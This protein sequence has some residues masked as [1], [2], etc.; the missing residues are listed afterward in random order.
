MRSAKRRLPAQAI[1]GIELRREKKDSRRRGFAIG[2]TI[3][4]L[5]GA[6]G[7]AMS[8]K[9]PGDSQ[10]LGALLGAAAG[11]AVYGGIGYAIGR[12]SDLAW[13]PVEILPDP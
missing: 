6:F 1:R 8:D 11:I 2:A 3:G 9:S 13:T 7:G 4:A 5:L 10:A 12:S